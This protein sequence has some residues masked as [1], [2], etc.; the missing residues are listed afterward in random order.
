PGF[1]R[2]RPDQR[3]ALEHD[4]CEPVEAMAVRR[5]LAREELE[6]G[7]APPAERAV[8]LPLVPREGGVDRVELAHLDGGGADDAARQETPVDDHPEHA[9]RWKHRFAAGLEID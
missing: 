1:A 7:V 4:L 3:E 5:R 9:W 2:R 6:M 8:A